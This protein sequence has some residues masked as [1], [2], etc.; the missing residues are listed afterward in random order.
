M[1]YSPY[2]NLRT[3]LFSVHKVVLQSAAHTCSWRGLLRVVG[4]GGVPLQKRKLVNLP[5][6]GLEQYTQVKLKIQPPPGS[7]VDVVVEPSSTLYP[8]LPS[9]LRTRGSIYR[10]CWFKLR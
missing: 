9:G 8:R 4:G 10:S 7:F 5:I 6:I 1:F 2:S 3:L